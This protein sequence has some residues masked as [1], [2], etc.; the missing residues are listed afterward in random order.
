MKSVAFD[1]FLSVGAVATVMLL[2]T[3]VI[4]AA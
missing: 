2:L 4:K 1:I 3:F